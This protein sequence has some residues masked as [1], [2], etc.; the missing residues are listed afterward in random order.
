MAVQCPFCKEFWTPS[1]L[2]TPMPVPIVVGT[3]VVAIVAE[4]GQCDCGAW[5]YEGMEDV[6]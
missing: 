6:E 2:L 3:D 4:G 1:I 5:W